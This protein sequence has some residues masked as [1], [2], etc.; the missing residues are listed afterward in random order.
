LTSLLPAFFLAGAIVTFISRDSIVTY[1][2]AKAKKISSFGI[3]AAA[4]FLLATDSMTV[5]AVANGIYSAGAGL[6]AAFVLLWV[7][8]AA[9]ILALVYTEAVLGPEMVAARVIAALLT[10]VIIGLGIARTFRTEDK[11]R[12]TSASANGGHIISRNGAILLILLVG[13]GFR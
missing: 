6:G 8:S 11:N 13:C 4:G 12:I 5:I 3:A 9:N 1:L 7:A 2:G 10:S